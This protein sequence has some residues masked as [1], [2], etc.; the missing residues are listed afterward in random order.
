MQ[1]NAQPLGRGNLES[2][3]GRKKITV[4]GSGRGASLHR[5]LQNQNPHFSRKDRARNGAP[6]LA[7]V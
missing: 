1:A 3:R 6:I 2:T 4:N 5:E 7:E